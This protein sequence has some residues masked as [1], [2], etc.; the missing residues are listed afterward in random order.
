MY[1]QS[2]SGVSDDPFLIYLEQG[3]HRIILYSHNEPFVLSSVKLA[4]PQKYIGYDEYLKNTARL[5]TA[6]GGNYT[7]R[8]QLP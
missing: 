6:T 5:K 4:A 8:K 7:R 3:T 2:D 1:A